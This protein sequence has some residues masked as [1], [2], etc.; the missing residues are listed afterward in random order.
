MGICFRS[1]FSVF[2]LV[3]F[4]ISVLQVIIPFKTEALTWDR[5]W[6]WAKNG[7]T[8]FES[9][10]YAGDIG[11]CSYSNKNKAIYGES[12]TKQV[13]LNESDTISFGSYYYGSG[14]TFP[15]AISFA[16]NEKM[17]KLNGAPCIEF[18]QCLYLP[19]TDTLVTKQ[20]LINNIVRSLVIYKN[21]SERIS[22]NF[23]EPIDSTSYSFDSTNP[24]YIFQTSD[25]VSYAWPIGGVAASKNGKWLA[26]EFRQR[27]IGLL[28]IETLEMKRISTLSFSYMSGYDPSTELAVSNTGNNVAVMGTN[29]G[30]N[31]Y[32]VDPS[33]GDEATDS[34][35]SSI[36][37]ISNPCKQVPVDLSAFIYRF[38]NGLRPK[39]NSDGGELSFYASSYSEIT[40]KV[41]LKAWGYTVKKLDYLALGDSFS[42]GEGELDDNYYLD[43]T[44]EDFQKCH[45]ST[46][47][48]PYLIANY[49][50]I[51]SMYMKSIACSGAMMTDVI[52]LN[53]NY[54]GQGNR[55]ADNGL[56]L[57]IPQK[58]DSQND[59][60]DKFIPGRV[61]QTS[62]VEEHLPRIITIGIGGNDAGFM[63]K[64]KA[65]IGPGTCSW[66]DNNQDK[67]KTAI[68]IKDLFDDLVQT[69][70]DLY[71]ASEFSKIYVIGYPKIISTT[72]DCDSLTDYL[73]DAKERQFMDEG[74]K[75]LNE[76]IKAAAFRA[77]FK[78][79]D[80]EN[81]FGDSVLCGSNESSAMNALKTGDDFGPA[82]KLNWFKVMGQE[83]FHPNT[84]G[85][86][87]IANTINNSIGNLFDYDY[88]GFGIIICVKDNFA[89]K[90]SD[91][92]G[93]GENNN[94]PSQKIAKF[95]SSPDD[96]LDNKQKQLTVKEGILSPD[97]EARIMISSEPQELGL[98]KTD[99][100][101]LLDITVDLP[102]NLQDGYHTMHLFGTSMS[103]EQIELYQVISYEKP[104]IEII[105]DIVD[106]KKDE[107]IEG[108]SI[109]VTT[110]S[111][112]DITETNLN[113]FIK[114]LGNPFDLSIDQEIK[115]VSTV[116]D[117][118]DV[119]LSEEDQAVK[120]DLNINNP[121]YI[122]PVLGI[123]CVIVITA[124]ILETKKNTKTSGK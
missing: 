58:V 65:C 22:L 108:N 74:I 76:V 28:N 35:M 44:N 83:S 55:L 2:L 109:V 119:V 10:E 45:N 73:L 114:Q 8:M 25:P 121:N 72:G 124:I 105:E 39:Y 57:T 26:L 118:S 96:R 33:C 86:S 20:Y 37:P 79:V 68:E 82:D 89:P 113:N 38:S 106:V 46:R 52:G 7:A 4:I 77:G 84:T 49:S 16:G 13:C 107:I 27:G 90:Y 123:F 18:N 11:W 43:G 14:W 88:C 80:I 41:T 64:L 32:D 60:I 36:S 102:N 61:R 69:Y 17:F 103:G 3:I 94:Y 66:A 59:A 47:S 34:R 111:N 9:K 120:N 99:N 85:H 31:V 42:S 112:N 100:N 93:S 56:N 97:S 101:G 91:Y 15:V 67:E 95:V 117:K 6:F 92:W 40:R 1:K 110:T 87:L 54:W 71:K 19:D 51:N 122:Y 24:D 29:A 115:G 50:N 23:G 53:D 12:E 104:V 21:F 62:F 30:F 78:Y 5:S 75:Y 98:F 63:E 70:T 48:Y 81:S 116:A